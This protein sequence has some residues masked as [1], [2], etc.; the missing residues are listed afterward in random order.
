[1]AIIALVVVTM[2][3]P[4]SGNMLLVPMTGGDANQVARVALAGGAALVGAGP[5]RGSMVV[6]G[7]R[8]RIEREIMSWN[9]VVLAAPPAGCGTGR[10]PGALA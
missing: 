6:T 9:I 1:M 2:W 4:V 7:N 10:A 8:S 5:F 3:P